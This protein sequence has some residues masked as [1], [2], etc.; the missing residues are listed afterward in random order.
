MIKI[1]EILQVI[2]SILL[3]SSVLLQKR[4]ASLGSAFGGT[5]GTYFK[6]RGIEK[7]LFWGTIVLSIL[8]VINTLLLLVL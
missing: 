2:I 6:R 7:F 5:G 1:L 3:I 4:G 8:F